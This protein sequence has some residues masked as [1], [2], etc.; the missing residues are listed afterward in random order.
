MQKSELSNLGETLLMDEDADIK[1]SS[2]NPYLVIF[3]GKDSGKRHKLKPG[4][5]TIGRSPEADITIEDERI[6]RI[7]CEIKCSNGTITVED[8][9]SK[10]GT[11][12]DS[13]KISHAV[14]P[15][16]VSIQ[17]GHSLMK[18]EYKDKAEVEYEQS[19]T[20]QLSTD[21][22]TGI[23]NRQHFTNLALKEIA[24]ARRRKQTVGIIIID[25]DSFKSV[26]DTCGRMIGDLVF[27]Q[28][29][30]LI[31]ENKRTE[32]LLGRYGDKKFI[33]L[34]HGEV[35]KKS[36][37]RQ[38]ERI[39]KA[40]EGFKFFNADA[41]V[42]VTVSIGFYLDRPGNGKVESLLDALI[43][44][45]EQALYRVKEKSKNQTFAKRY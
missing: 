35:D 2:R 29:A 38:C 14:L 25:I 43:D 26:I 15:P 36:I 27:A 37:H 34:P 32:D 12:V 31:R 24:Y 19:L 44:K 20:H 28:L 33:I 4:I 23:F 42:Q 21:A 18:I 3:I 39:R 10:N 16:G 30:D 45:A 22:L 5:I 41:C 9:G 13:Y 1:V 8:K 40:I 11:Y 17:L 7:H 6:S